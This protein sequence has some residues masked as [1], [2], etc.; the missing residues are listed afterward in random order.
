MLLEL[1]NSYYTNC[2]IDK[3]YHDHTVV[4]WHMMLGLDIGYFV[5]SQMTWG[6]CIEFDLDSH[7]NRHRCIEFD[8]DSHMSRQQ[9]IEFDLDSH[10]KRVRRSMPMRIR[11]R[12]A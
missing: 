4:H 11:T 9:C 7:M 3:R 2:N 6:F 5:E 12:G 1:S 8:L 10:M